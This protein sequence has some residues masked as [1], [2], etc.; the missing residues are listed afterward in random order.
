VR[1]AIAG[2]GLLP[3]VSGDRLTRVEFE[4]RY[5]AMP[6]VKKAELIEGVVYVS[7]PLRL[8]HGECDGLVAHWLGAYALRTPGVKSASNATD[9]LDE[10]NEPQPDQLLRLLPEAGG[11][12]RVDDD[13]YLS[14]GPELVVEVALSS[15]SYDLH[16]KKEVYRRHGVREY[17]VIVLAPRTVRWFRNDAGTFVETPRGRDGLHRSSAFPGLWLDGRALLAGDTTRVMKALDRGLASPEHAS[18]VRALRAKLRKR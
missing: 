7:S 5:D 10:D 18:L 3:L 16:Q 11:Q 12:S 2:Q 8:D 14:G 1:S 13:G 6:G 4:R 15:A 17:V 9:R